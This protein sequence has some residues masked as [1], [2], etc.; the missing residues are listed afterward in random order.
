MS[1]KPI[2][3]ESLWIYLGKSRLAHVT[4]ETPRQGWDLVLGV[5]EST[6]IIIIVIIIYYCPHTFK[7]LTFIYLFITLRSH[8]EVSTA[9]RSGNS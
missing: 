1:D 8:H 2:L 7:H 9:L 4:Q 3:R 5:K 6:L